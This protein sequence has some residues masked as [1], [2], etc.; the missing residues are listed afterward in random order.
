VGDRT[1][2]MK[3]VT[4]MPKTE[5]LTDRVRTQLTEVST[6]TL[7]TQLF[8]RGLRN[9][10]LYGVLPMN[11]EHAGFVGEAFTLRY[12]PAR[13]DLD[14]VESFEDP[15]H[16]QRKAV[17]STAAGHVLIMDS[18][19]TARA[20]TAGDILIT[21]L[22]RRGVTAVVTDGSFRD[23]PRLRQL[24]FPTFAAGSSAMLN[25]AL[26]HA[27][28]F[29]VPIGCAGVPVFPGDV[30][31]GDQE[32]VVCIPRHLA[33]EVAEAA[34]EQE[35]LEAFVLEKIKAGAPLVG[36]YPPSAEVRAEYERHRKAADDDRR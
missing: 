2:A 35:R 12:I 31:V 8:K 10:F 7:T 34:V 17:E 28:D 5:P 24:D 11:P 3:E 9:T 19:G 21:R 33:A 1:G 27:V 18:R 25:L 30:L 14:V 26:H 15:E 20:A 16:P 36:T 13:E 23:S 22:I 4:A 29:Q 32:G 6:A